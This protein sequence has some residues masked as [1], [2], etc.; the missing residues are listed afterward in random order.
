MRSTRL[1]FSVLAITLF[2][3][4]CAREQSP[5][6]PDPSLESALDSEVSKH[7][8]HR[9]RGP[10][11]LVVAESNQSF[12]ETYDALVGALDAN[13]N[14]GIVA[15]L[16]HAAN[17]AGVGLELPPESVRGVSDGEPDD[18]ASLGPV[19]D[20]HASAV[21]LGDASDDQ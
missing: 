14:V 5:L 13:P 10:A 18:G 6:S 4:G 8:R 17:A 2:I 21:G 7:D 1:F 9:Q 3:V 16:D 15:T 12:E 11:G 19:G 20:P